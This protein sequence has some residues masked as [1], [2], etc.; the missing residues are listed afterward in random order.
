M[1]AGSPLIWAV[2]VLGLALPATYGVMKVKNAWEM[3]ASYD[4]GVEA[5]KGAASAATVEAA[6]KTAAAERQA[7]EETP[8]LPD[9]SAILAK[10]KT[11]ASCRERGTIK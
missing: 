1:F 5:G 10:C 7:V 4:K 6:T 3:Q 9:K 8:L 11:S 2:V